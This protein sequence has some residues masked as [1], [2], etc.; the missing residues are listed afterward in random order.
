MTM[1]AFQGRFIRCSL[2]WKKMLGPEDSKYSRPDHQNNGED[3]VTGGWFPD[4][5]GYGECK[6]K[7]GDK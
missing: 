4:D 1:R 6:R 2:F 3:E 7:E 5:Y